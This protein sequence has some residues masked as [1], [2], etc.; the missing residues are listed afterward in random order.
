MAEPRFLDF[1]DRIDGGGRGQSGDTFEGG[2]L[3]SLLGNLLASPYG[4]QN[5]ERRARRDAFYAG[6][7]MAASGFN[8]TPVQTG[9]EMSTGGDPRP[10][11][12]RQGQQPAPY[13][14]QAPS[15]LERFGGQQPA[16]YQPQAP[17]PLEQFGGQPPAA[18]QAPAQSPLEQFGG[19]QPPSYDPSPQMIAQRFMADL[20][21]QYPERA[22]AIA[23]SP[24]AL[25]IFEHYVNNNYT[26]PAM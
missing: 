17:S 4:S 13:Q 6:E 10:A 16:P 12:L 18:Y 25:G 7:P 5:P 11:V 20:R 23:N 1:L 21:A 26:L 2:G 15:P 24:S 22:S 9:R 14:P 19:Q 3:L 8:Q